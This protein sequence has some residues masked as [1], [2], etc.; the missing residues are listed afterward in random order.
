MKIVNVK[1]KS[2]DWLQARCG[3]VTGSHCADVLWFLKNGKESAARYNYRAKLIA[4]ILT[5]MVDSEG[6]VSKEMEWGIFN[7]PFARAAYEVRMGPEYEVDI[8]GF[9]LHDTIARMGG[10]PDGLIGTDGG[11]EI[12][13]PNTSTHIK[14]MFDGVVPE[15]HEPQMMFYMALTG[16]KWM[17]FVSFDPRLPKRH[18]LFIRRLERDEK[19]IAEIEAAVIKFLEEVDAAIA[20][21]E[22]LNPPLEDEAAVLAALDEDALAEDPLCITEG[23]LDYLFGEE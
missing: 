19:R 11:L 1:Q 6:Y 16:R 18:R 17:D 9:V 10:S 13:C 15:E 22:E 12:K 5:H 7:E 21:L 8:V 3:L 23:D 14:W 2:A 4:E 20:K